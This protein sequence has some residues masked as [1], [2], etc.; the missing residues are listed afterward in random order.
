MPQPH[1]HVEDDT[2]VIFVEADVVGAEVYASADTV[3]L[4]FRTPGFGTTEDG[5][6][7]L[8]APDAPFVTSRSDR[9]G[10]IPP[11]EIN[12][13]KRGKWMPN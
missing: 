2:P 8:Y 9:I 6:Y 11:S 4:R 13:L 5:E 10:T 3:T 12:V 1:E 7:V